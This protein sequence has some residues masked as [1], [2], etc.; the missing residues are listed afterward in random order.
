ME[1]QAAQCYPT[2]RANTNGRIQNCSP[3]VYCEMSLT[4]SVILIGARSIS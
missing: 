4:I 3:I 1:R 2:L